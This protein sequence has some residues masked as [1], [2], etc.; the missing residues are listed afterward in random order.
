M[1][2]RGNAHWGWGLRDITNQ[3]VCEAVNGGVV[4]L[5][6]FNYMLFCTFPSIRRSVRI[7]RRG[8][9]AGIPQGDGRYVEFMGWGISG[10]LTANIASY[11]GV[12]WFGQ[13][14]MFW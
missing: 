6:T 12:S 1:G 7:S 9:A 2:T 3:W 5:I 4:P 8:R 13:L 10:V 14:N 11:L